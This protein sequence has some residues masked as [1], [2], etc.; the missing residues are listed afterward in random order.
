MCDENPF[1][2]C[3]NSVPFDFIINNAQR[4]CPQKEEDDQKVN[5]LFGCDS[6]PLVSLW[7]NIF[8]VC[9]IEILEV[10]NQT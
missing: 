8:S 1:F 6:H 10:E 2:W 3:S 4:C 9:L 7:M 5:V